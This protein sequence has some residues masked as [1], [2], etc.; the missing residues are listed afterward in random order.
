MRGIRGDGDNRPALLTTEL[1]HRLLEQVE[2]PA[3]VD[4]KSLL[5]VVLRQLLGGPHA[6]NTGGID[7][8]V[9]TGQIVEQSAADI[10]HLLRVRHVQRFSCKRIA[11]LREGDVK[12]G[13]LCARLCEGLRGGVAD[14]FSGPGHPDGFAAKI[15]P[16]HY[17][18][19]RESSAH[20]ASRVGFFASITK[21]MSP[22]TLRQRAASAIMRTESRP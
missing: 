13:H 12:T 14:A 10:S 9:Q 21:S 7:Q 4:R 19:S 11:C 6:Q 17:F 22:C 16:G 8:H 18:T 15:Q 1:A 5:P 3:N 2:G 20:Q